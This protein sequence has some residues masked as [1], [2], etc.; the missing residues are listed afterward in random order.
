MS[1][2]TSIAIV[3]FFCLKFYHHKKNRS[4]ARSHNSFLAIFEIFL[5]KSISINIF[6]VS[7]AIVYLIQSRRMHFLH[8]HFLRAARIAIGVL[9]K[10]I[11]FL[12]DGT[13]VSN[14]M[15]NSLKHLHVFVDH[16]YEYSQKE[17]IKFCYDI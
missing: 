13:I 1:I 5:L 4:H 16:Q 2:S 12:D 15:C 6:N 9:L 11:L 17:S 10:A 14:E 7:Q 8:F 3:D